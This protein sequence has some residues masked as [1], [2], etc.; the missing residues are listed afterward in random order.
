MTPDQALRHAWTSVVTPEDYDTHMA[1]VGQA[2]ANAQLVRDLLGSFALPAR[3]KVLIAGAGTGQMFDYLPHDTFASYRLTCSDIN[4][5]FLARLRERLDCETAVDDVEDSQLDP[6]FAVI[7]LVLVF[8]HVD[9]RRT[10]A[11][12]SRLAAQR[13]IV[14]LQENPPSISV[15][16]SPGR[17]LPGT[18]QVFRDQAPPHL[19]PLSILTEEFA[20]HG[21][22]MQYLREA[23]VPD[24]K[25][26]IAALFT[27][28][29]LLP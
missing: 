22:R 12:L 9:L 11:S 15:A 5:R 1:T 7:I 28:E 24:G 14:V 10:P 17:H 6:G 16:V 21:F 23:S 19:V 25:K 18:M 3:S 8:E 20:S 2:Q 4:P 27:N 13:I 29:R 26:M